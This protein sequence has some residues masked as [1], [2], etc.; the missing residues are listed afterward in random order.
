[1]I[2]KKYYICRRVMPGDIQLGFTVRMQAYKDGKGTGMVE[3]FTNKKAA[4]DAKKAADFEARLEGME[5][6]WFHSVEWDWV[7]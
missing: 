5:K 4:E 6:Q 7:T 3:Y 2:K 1:M